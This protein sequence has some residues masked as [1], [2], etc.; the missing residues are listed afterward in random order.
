M[1]AGH[2]PLFMFLVGHAVVEGG[3]MMSANV[4]TGVLHDLMSNPVDEDCRDVQHQ[5]SGV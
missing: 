3:A 5:R 1:P 2:L 4:S